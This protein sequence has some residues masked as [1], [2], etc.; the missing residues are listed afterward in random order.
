MLKFSPATELPYVWVFGASLLLSKA[1][2]DKFML[3]TK[4]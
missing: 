2:W 3:E 1:Y 4:R